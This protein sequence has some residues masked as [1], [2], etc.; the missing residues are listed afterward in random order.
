MRDKI[1]LFKKNGY[2]LLENLISE[3]KC[4]FYKKKLNEY[5]DKY[6]SMYAQD[7]N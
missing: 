6:S 5:Y 2:L 7:K 3:K 4:L 1:K